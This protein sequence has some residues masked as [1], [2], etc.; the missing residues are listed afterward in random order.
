MTQSKWNAQLQL[1]GGGE[2]V[3]ARVDIENKNAS[4][5][6]GWG[7]GKREKGST[8]ANN[9][10][11]YAHH[12]HIIRNSNKQKKNM[13]KTQPRLCPTLVAV[14]VAARDSEH[15]WLNEV[16]EWGVV[17]MAGADE[18]NNI[19]NICGSTGDGVVLD[20]KAHLPARNIA[21]E[22]VQG[23]VCGVGKPSRQH[24][25]QRGVEKGVGRGVDAHVLL[26]K[27]TLRHLPHNGSVCV[28]DV[29]ESRR[30]S[31]RRERSAQELLRVC[32]PNGTRN[33]VDEG[34]PV[35]GN[36]CKAE[37]AL[38]HVVCEHVVRNGGCE[39]GGWGKPA[40]LEA[41]WAQRV[42][43]RVCRHVCGAEAAP[44]D[45]GAALRALEAGQ[46]LCLRADAA[47]VL[48]GAHGHEGCWGLCVAACTKHGRAC[49][50]LQAVQE[51]FPEHSAGSLLGLALLAFVGPVVRGELALVLEALLADGAAVCVDVFV[52]RADVSAECRL[53]LELLIAALVVAAEPGLFLV[54]DTVLSHPRSVTKQFTTVWAG[55]PAYDIVAGGG[56]AGV[57]ALLTGAVEAWTKLGSSCCSCFWLSWS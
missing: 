23:L 19:L 24:I 11:S 42:W 4:C 33:G 44:V 55:C 56:V 32:S 12:T 8:K 5:I 30:R 21:L 50:Q 43:Q 20:L 2:C 17:L 40:H 22:D 18:N 53:R 34:P 47:R 45:G 7:E 9:T 25:P 27:C 57:V 35:R 54:L 15:D 46:V 38:V 49:R 14:E 10:T 6:R 48:A 41:A 31:N 52:L 51:L 28:G 16:V 13:R 36:A 1:E 29:V 37:R 3:L 26:R 39:E